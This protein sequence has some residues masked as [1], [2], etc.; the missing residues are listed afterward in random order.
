MKTFISILLLSLTLTAGNNQLSLA[1]T[2]L[3]HKDTP[4]NHFL[5]L[6]LNLEEIY[7]FQSG[8]LEL[9]IGLQALGILDKSDDFT[10][11]DTIDKSRA[12]LH[13]LSLDYYPTNQLLLSLGRQ[14]LDINLLRGSFDGFLGVAKF[15]TFSLKAFYF[16]RYSILDSTYYKNAKIDALYGFNFNYNQGILESEI[17]SFT[18]Y[19]HTV[20]NLYVGLHPGDFS[21]GAEHLSFTSDLLNDEKAYK[22]HL[23]Y[24]YA[25]SYMEI[26]YFHVY[27]GTL[28]NIF[29]LGG[30]EFKNFQLQG[31][32]DQKEA[33][34]IYLN[35]KY[36][37]D[38]WYTNL[39]YGYTTFAS[40][41]GPSIQYTG[42]ELGITLSKQF[43]DLELSASLLTQKSDQP[44]VDGERTTWLQ[45]QLK[46]RF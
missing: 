24:Q 44:G 39:Y 43:G 33:E 4:N 37:Q 17:T 34:K 6:Y 46:Y 32:L 27:E 41:W 10:L 18:Y 7:S 12:L 45:T 3:T 28:R 25:N 11:F 23:G 42:K 13:S 40:L 9:R 1:Y 26:G 30:T 35:V 22:F 21:L 20:N 5:S 15:D 14:S 38:D 2:S 29:A 19:G 8:D 36:K 31:F 16:D